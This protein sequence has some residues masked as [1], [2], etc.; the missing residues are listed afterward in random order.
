MWGE[1]HDQGSLIFFVPG[2]EKYV[3]TN[4]G[5]S[6]GSPFVGKSLRWEEPS[7]GRAFLGKSLRWEEY[8]LGRAFVGKSLRW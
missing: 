8:S 2:I 5:S 3:L 1:G 7:L 4:E 6:L